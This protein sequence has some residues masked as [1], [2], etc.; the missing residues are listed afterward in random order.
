MT[1]DRKFIELSLKIGGIF[2]SVPRRSINHS[3][4]YS[5]SSHKFCIKLASSFQLV[6]FFKF[7]RKNTHN[8]MNI[9]KINPLPTAIAR[10]EYFNPVSSNE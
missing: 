5:S 4:K 10:R 7:R 2:S 8:D 6:F 9:K 1:K 3:L